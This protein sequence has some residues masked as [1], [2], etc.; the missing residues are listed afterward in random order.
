MVSYSRSQDID[1][2]RDLACHKPGRHTDKAVSCCCVSLVRDKVCS[3]ACK[4]NHPNKCLLSA[5]SCSHE[6]SHFNQSVTA[7]EPAV[8]MPTETAP[9]C[10]N[11]I[12]R[13]RASGPAATV[14]GPRPWR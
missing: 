4:E 2:Y 5:R 3:K 1:Q 7:E 10:I 11:S 13:I 6:S 8:E 9:S 12:N 14:P